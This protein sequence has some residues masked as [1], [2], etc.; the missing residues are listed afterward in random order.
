MPYLDQSMLKTHLYEEIQSEIVQAD[1]TIL[2]NGTD[3]ALDEVRGYLSKYDFDAEM[4]LPE[5]DRNKK[6]L[7]VCKD[8]AVWHIIRLANPN[9]EIEFRRILYEDAMKWLRDVQKGQIVL[10]IPLPVANT[11]NTGSTSG[12]VVWSSNSKRKNQF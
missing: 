9:I 6:L 4:A 8:V 1:N 5:A 12:T 7:S 2:N 11:S 10:N 3:T